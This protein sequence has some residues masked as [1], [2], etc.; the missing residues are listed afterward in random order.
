MTS[1]T[2]LWIPVSSLAFWPSPSLD[3]FPVDSACYDLEKG[4]TP[5]QEARSIAGH[6]LTLQNQ[7]RLDTERQGG[8]TPH[9]AFKTKG[10]GS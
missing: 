9:N 6:H 3:F 1:P 4:T 8:L 10:S 5:G 2:G 7:T